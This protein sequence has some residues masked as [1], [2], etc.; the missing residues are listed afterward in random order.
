MPRGTAAVEW[1][2]QSPHLF[3][4][5]LNLNL[6]PQEELRERQA[7]KGVC[8][9]GRPSGWRVSQGK[10]AQALLRSCCSFP[11][12]V[13]CVRTCIRM[14]ACR[15]FLICQGAP[16]PPKWSRRGTALFMAP[17]GL[18][19]TRAAP[20]QRSPAERA[21]LRQA[22]VWSG[23]TGPHCPWAACSFPVS[24]VTNYHQLGS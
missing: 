2:M 15:Y 22:P 8:V 18:S 23:D 16:P 10:E 11:A 14:L 6:S 13:C 20:Q 3:T 21:A 1:G 7:P 19:F 5:S 17:A 12:F 4:S 9:L 24:I